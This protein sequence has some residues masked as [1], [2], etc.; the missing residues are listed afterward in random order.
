MYEKRQSYKLFS[1]LL[2]QKL[3][4]KNVCSFIYIDLNTIFPN[5]VHLVEKEIKVK[6]Y[7]ISS[8][9]IAF[10]YLKKEGNM[11]IRLSSV[12]TFFTV[13]LV[14]I[15]FCCFEKV[16]FFVPPSCDD[17]NIDFYIYCFNFNENYI[18][19]H[20]IQ[21]IWDAVICNQH[22]NEKFNS[23]E[24]GINNI[25]NKSLETGSKK[26]KSDIYFSIPLYFVMNK[27]FVLFIKKFN[28][29][30]I[31]NHI[32][33]CLNFIKEPKYFNHH[34]SMI[35][36]LLT[37]FFKAYILCD[38]SYEQIYKSITIHYNIFHKKEDI[39]D[40][41]DED[42]EDEHLD[43]HGN[44]NNN[45]EDGSGNNN[46]KHLFDLRDKKKNDIWEPN[47]YEN[48][49]GESDYSLIYEYKNVPSEISISETAWDSP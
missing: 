43:K 15:L 23:K 12:L 48:S 6:N 16:S 7:F 45:L 2:I 32:N 30:Y 10:N 29:F 37:N 41:E 25:T 9:I 13:G 44:F 20:Y 33:I 49:S 38:N 17:I 4:S 35:K 31:K 1:E 21:Y 26:R 11:I 46:F 22:I 19:R 47:K 5:Y 18:Y 28:S 27:H 34:K 39:S 36:S 14:Y 40:D 42:E 24:M 8:L 3:K